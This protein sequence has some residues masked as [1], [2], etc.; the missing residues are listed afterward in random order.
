MEKRHNKTRISSEMTF[1]NFF[2]K[3]YF[4]FFVNYC[5]FSL[6]VD[7]YEDVAEEAFVELWRHWDELDSHAE[8]VLFTWTKKA[9]ELLSMSHHRKHAKEPIFVEFN[10]CIDDIPLR[11]STDLRYSMEESFVEKE[12][13]KYYLAE[14]NKRLSPKEQQLFSCII[15]NEMSI[16]ET[17]HILSKSEK[18]VSVAITRLRVKLRSKILPEIFPKSSSAKK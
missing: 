6:H 16:R 17:A 1:E 3:Y 12:T 11:M 14:I 7:N 4:D 10:E 9:A 15:I 5:K 18:A 13:Y 8:F 2:E